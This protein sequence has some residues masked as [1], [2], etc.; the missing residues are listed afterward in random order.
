[1]EYQSVVAEDENV[2]TVSNLQINNTPRDPLNSYRSVENSLY[3]VTASISSWRHDQ[4][5]QKFLPE[6][7]RVHQNLAKML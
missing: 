4:M 3:S 5:I 2:D 7:F 6:I 1:M